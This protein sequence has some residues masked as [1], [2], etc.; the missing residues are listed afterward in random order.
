MGR[1]HSTVD[2]SAF[3]QQNQALQ[4]ELNKSN[5]QLQQFQQQSQQ[6]VQALTHQ[7]HQFQ[8]Q[9]TV[10]QQ[11]AQQNAKK[12]QEEIK[13]HNELKAQLANSVKQMKEAEKRSIIKIEDLSN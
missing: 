4:A 3:A 7:S 11:Q 10:T 6:Q 2:M 13:R 8:S 5:A 9:L 1:S 12:H